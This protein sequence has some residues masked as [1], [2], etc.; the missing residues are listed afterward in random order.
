MTRPDILCIG[1]VHWD[2]IAHAAAPLL[3]GDDRP[4]R[5]VRRPGGVALNVAAA[6]A[7]LGLRPALVSAVGHDAEGAELAEAA[8]ALGVAAGFLHRAEGPTGV[9]VALEDPGG[10]VAAVADAATLEDAGAAILAPLDDGR[11]AGPAAPWEATAVVDGNLSAA[12]LA[13]L[14]AGPWLRAADVRAVAASNAKAA[15]LAPVTALPR[16][17]LYLNL[18]EAR[19]LGAPAGADAPTAAAALSAQGPAR[20]LVTDGPGPAALGSAGAVLVARPPQV[21]VR[22]VTGA[23][24]CLMAHHIAAEARG[25]DAQAALGLA[26]AAAA[27][28]VAGVEPAGLSA[29]CVGAGKEPA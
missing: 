25:L 21:L 18:A 27:R 1:A 13:E 19:A 23:G 6:L 29:G 26:V 10:L 4:G 11:L 8:A 17:T 14:A 15:R 28:H 20:V 5:V 22:Q 3:R 24:D 7:R 2:V 16:A 9:Y 12:L